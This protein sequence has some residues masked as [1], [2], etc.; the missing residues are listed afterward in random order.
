VYSAFGTRH[1]QIKSCS[2]D[3]WQASARLGL[4]AAPIEIRSVHLPWAMRE[5]IWRKSPASEI[6]YAT[7]QSQKV[8]P[9]RR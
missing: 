8:L 5:L 4:S 9:G 7:P 6:V 3:I 1:A 2:A